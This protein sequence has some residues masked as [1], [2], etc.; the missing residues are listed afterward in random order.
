[1]KWI[2][3]ILLLLV[4]SASFGQ[5]FSYSYVDP[6]SKKTN[7]VY[8]PSGQ[9]SVT[10]SYYG[11]ANT[12][13]QADF[14]NG[15]FSA[16][17]YSV[18]AAS[19][20]PCEGLKTQTQ[21]NTNQ[22]ITNNIIS[23]LTSVTAAATMSVTSSISSVSSQSAGT[24][25]G[26]SV[27]NSS[28]NS[29]GG[30]SSKENKNGQNN[31]GSKSNNQE[32]GTSG[33]PQ[34]GGTTTNSTQGSNKT[35]GGSSSGTNQSTEGGNQPSGSPVGGNTAQNQPNT[36]PNTNKTEPNTGNSGS[37]TGNSSNT[38]QTGSNTG[39]N[40]QSGTNT[41]QNGGS[42]TQSGTNTGNSGS[43]TNNTGGSGGTNTGNSGSNTG[44]SGSG[45]GN[46][47]NS[48]SN[49]NNTGG[50]GGSGGGTDT[51]T[52]TTDPTTTPTDSKSGGNGGTTNSVANAAEASS[53]G[54][55]SNA[56]EGSG[57]GGKGGAKSNIRVGSI[58]GTGDI[59]AIRSA[60]DNA[61]SFKATMS[62]TKSNTDNSR[63][64]GAL[65]NFT[66]AINNSNL[67]FYGAFTNKAKSNTLICA[68]S[69][70][71]NFNYD[72]F[73]TTTVLESHRFNKFSLMGG[74]NYTIGSMA[75]TS[76]SNIS[77][78]GG[79]FYM[80]K[81]SKNLSGNMLLLAVYSPFTKF[82]EGTW[83]Q[84]GTLLVPFSSWDYSISKNFKYN[85]SFSGTWEVGKSVLQ[86]QILT[87][88]KIML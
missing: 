65:L 25:L 70:M 88:G 11:V 35:E 84:S 3:S 59:V 51:K 62:V 83:W 31:S 44:N 37:N 55:T 32:S 16:W 28:D 9:N 75:E 30:G 52:N 13:T 80:F 54:S 4:S 64:K 5:G 12:F 17:M 50:S 18:S 10:I 58:I 71:I 72:L 38:T 85:I 68:N 56:S 77:A 73:N 74:L 46:T 7:T 14:Q 42:S 39:N 66:T 78:V 61:N 43:N 63:A 19:T 57:G 76:F 49:T 24:A 86:Y 67:T 45:G 2:F 27:N 33:Q 15:T 53:G 36:S 26:N 6:C 34:G 20:Q 41:G 40:T 87:G 60:E 79:G 29:S 22:I 8:I 48:G 47:G 81:A 23:T 1:M 69:T 21:T 82:Y